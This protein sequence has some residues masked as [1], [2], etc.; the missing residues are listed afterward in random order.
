M[1]K[2]GIVDIKGGL[3]NQLFQLSFTKYLKSQG[4]KVYLDT[5]FFNSNHIFPRKLEL[6][7]SQFGFK[8]VKFKNNFIFRTFDSVF[9]EDDSFDNSDLKFINRFVGYYQNLKYVK[10]IKEDLYKILKLDTANKNKDLVALHIRKTDYSIIG[11]ELSDLYYQNAINEILKINNKLQFDIFTDDEN[12]TLD[13]NI[14]RNINKIYKPLPEQSAIDVIKLM[15]NYKNYILANSS[16]SALAA[17]IS[18]IGN[19]LVM[20]P[21]PWWKNSN[22]SLKGI[23]SSW[24]KVKN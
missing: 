22:V 16:F 12:L 20:Y 14:Y 13:N 9:V 19:Q 5:S 23:P 21:N 7:L 24:I 3:G 15:I 17:Y 6:D 11:Q 2:V 10:L 4:I 18:P 1:I 8:E